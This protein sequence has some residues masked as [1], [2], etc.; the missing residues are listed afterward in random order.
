VTSGK[1]FALEPDLP[2]VAESGLKGYDVDQWF[3]VL[4][5]AGI[6]TQVVEKLNRE[7]VRIVNVRSMRERLTSQH[8]VPSPSSSSEFDAVLRDDIA[9]W[10]RLIRQIGVRVD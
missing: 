8:F 1:R 3:A 10:S 5:P 6:P 9:R 4:G 7:I 2:A